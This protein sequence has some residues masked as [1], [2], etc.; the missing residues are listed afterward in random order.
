MR[1]T[2]NDEGAVMKILPGGVRLEARVLVDLKQP[3]GVVQRHPPVKRLR[4]LVL[5]CPYR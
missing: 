3:F 1:P 2:L 5:R 4:C